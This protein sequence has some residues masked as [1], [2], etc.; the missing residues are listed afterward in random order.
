MEISMEQITERGIFYEHQQFVK[1][2]LEKVTGNKELKDKWTQ[3]QNIVNSN[4][5]YVFNDIEKIKSA[6]VELHANR[7]HNNLEEASTMIISNQAISHEKNLLNLVITLATDKKVTNNAVSK[8]SPKTSD[9]LKIYQ[10]CFETYV[11]KGL[12]RRKTKLK[13]LIASKKKLSVKSGDSRTTKTVTKSPEMCEGVIDN[14]FNHCETTASYTIDTKFTVCEIV[15]SSNSDNISKDCETIIW[16][17]EQFETTEMSLDC[18]DNLLKHSEV[19]TS[20]EAL[21][22]S[23][24]IK[25]S[26]PDNS[27][28]DCETFIWDDLQYEMIEMSERSIE[29]SQDVTDVILEQSEMTSSNVAVTTTASINPPIPDIELETQGVVDDPLMVQATESI[30]N[31]SDS[32]D[33]ENIAKLYETLNRDSSNFEIMEQLKRCFKDKKL[34][35]LRNVFEWDDKNSTKKATKSKLSVKKKRQRKANNEIPRIELDSLIANDVTEQEVKIRFK[36]I[37]HLFAELESIGFSIYIFNHKL[38]ELLLS[39]F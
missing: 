7:I 6:L 36:C 25:S 29:M 22:A 17:D 21:T 4:E 18:N 39:R 1:D 32:N 5:S 20:N 19:N 3:I 28:E 34:A 12:E 23:E 9:P 15:D 14:P 37:A 10:S 13:K 35:K 11:Q 38:P 24:I 2:T 27:S 8:N 26:N 16:D 31:H 30:D 33:G